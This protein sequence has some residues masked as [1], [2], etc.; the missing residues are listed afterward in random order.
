MFHVP[1]L[2]SI[3]LVGL[4]TPWPTLTPWLGACYANAEG[5]FGQLPRGRVRRR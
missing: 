3:G 5:R 4:V 2:P 1:M